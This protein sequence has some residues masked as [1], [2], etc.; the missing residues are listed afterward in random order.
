MRKLSYILPILFVVSLV[1]CKPTETVT[2]ETTNTTTDIVQ[3]ETD[4]VSNNTEV[5][6]TPSDSNKREFFASIERSP[7]FGKC[8]AYKMTIYTD[9]FVEYEGFSSV[10]MIGKYT[11]TVGSKTLKAFRS[12]AIAIGFMEMKDKYDGMVTD[13]PS[14]TTAIVVDGV[15]KEVYRRFDYP[16][17]ILTFEKYFD[18]LLSSQKWISESG[19]PYPPER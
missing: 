9:G 16:K 12:Q 1:S 18:D 19:E 2:K 11:T 3:E 13:L 4:S 17:R 15:K 5:E 10:D 8:Q 6:T 7:C 14:A